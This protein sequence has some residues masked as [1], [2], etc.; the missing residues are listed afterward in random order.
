VDQR[1]ID[2]PPQALAELVGVAAVTL[3][4]RAVGLEPH[5]VRIDHGRDE[6]QG[7]ELPGHKERDGARLE[8][9]PGP[10]GQRMVTDQLRKSGSGR[11]DLSLADHG[12]IHGL[13]H[14]AARLAVDIQSNVVL[15]R[16]ALP[17]SVGLPA[18]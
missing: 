5:L 1:A 11:R 7:R 12:A 13:D 16:A 18:G 6:A 14:E 2:P 4:A 17:P 3:L 10:G 15:H 8:R 9:H